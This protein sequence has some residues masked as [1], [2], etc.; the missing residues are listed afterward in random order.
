MAPIV[1]GLAEQYKGK[2]S[3]N[4]IDANGDADAT[5]AMNIRVVPTYVFLD[6]SGEVM[7]RLE[8]GNSQKLEDAF[9]KA[10]GE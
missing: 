4:S 10:A 1:N 5:R 8:G 2:V 7:E 3:V 9:K 6:S